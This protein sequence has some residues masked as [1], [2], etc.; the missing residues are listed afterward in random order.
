MHA[1]RYLTLV[2]PG[3]PWVWLRG[4]L[5]GLVLALAF[6][7]SLDL[8]I[9]GTFIWPGLVELPLLIGLWTAVAAIWLIATVSAT[10]AF[11]PPITLPGRDEADMLFARAR[12]AYL[13]R[14]W[15][16][17]EA[18]VR[19]LLAVAPTDG[20]AQ[21]LRATLLRRTGRQAEA[22]RALDALARSDSGRPWQAEIAAELER[23]DRPADADAAPS[24]AVVR[25]DDESRRQEARS[26]AA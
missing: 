22:R 16:Q 15:V 19:D 23:L 11:P 12:D 3:L 5:S 18:R 1:L 9:L 25:C 7:V 21:L 10:A 2:W 4:S 8:S 6:A 13:A 26:A 14:D 20:E 24:A 17:A